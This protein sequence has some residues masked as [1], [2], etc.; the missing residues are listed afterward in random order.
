MK[1][2]LATLLWLLPAFSSAE[3]LR[4]SRRDVTLTLEGP[5]GEALP[6]YH[7][8]GGTY[9][10]AL[11]GERYAVRVTNVTGHRVEAVISVDGRDA[12]TGDVGDFRTQ[13]GYVVPAYGSVLIDGFRRSLEEVATFRFSSKSES[14]SARRGT[15]MNVGVVGVALFDEATPPR[16]VVPLALS[17]ARPEPTIGSG[18]RG[19]GGGGLGTHNDFGGLDQ[20]GPGHA[21]PKSQENAVEREANKGGAPAD[22]ATGSTSSADFDAAHDA[23]ETP[24]ESEQRA[25]K[26]RSQRSFNLGTEYGEGRDSPVVE[27]PF[28]RR[29]T[30]PSVVLGLYYDD[31]K[32]LVSRGIIQR[33]S[34]S[35]FAGPQPFP[36]NR[37]FAPPPP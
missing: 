17:R 34:V 2:L 4:S 35:N 5:N 33:P 18:G 36:V 32:G 20:A 11:T 31:R 6:T 8:N 1:T 15:P 24:D 23:Y 29:D 12:V 37:R 25:S 16:P 30:R 9:V 21:A 26:K 22:R 19:G 7:H 27:V 3:T 14:Y 28:L 13:R 10:Q